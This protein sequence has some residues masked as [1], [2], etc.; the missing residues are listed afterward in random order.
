MPVVTHRNVLTGIK[1]GEAMRRQVIKLMVTDTLD[2]FIRHTLKYK[3]NALLVTDVDGHPVGVVSKTDVMGAFYAGFELSTPLEMIM[4]GPPLFCRIDDR[5]E[6]A[7]ETMHENGVHRLYVTAEDGQDAVIGTLAYPDIVGLLYRFCSKCKKNIALRK[8]GENNGLS[9][10]RLRARDVMSTSVTALDTQANLVDIMEVLSQ[11]RFGAVLITDANKNAAGVVSKT[12]LMIAFRHGMGVD[13]RAA[14][15]MTTPVR[16]CKVDDY[17]I[18]VIRDMIF[19]DLHRLFVQSE[20]SDEIVGVISLTDAAKVRSGS[21]S[22]CT[23][24]RFLSPDR[25]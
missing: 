2:I 11:H 9:E 3:V 18:D 13:E 25:V 16:T 5:L 24:S 1:V 17:I 23:A 8:P 20:S 4:V 10:T 15:I 12:D 7:L 14:A 21:C 22:A 19:S 6:S